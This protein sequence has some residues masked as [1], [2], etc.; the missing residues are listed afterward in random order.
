MTFGHGALVALYRALLDQHGPQAWWP[1]E[2]PFEIM[3]GALLIQRTAWRNAEQALARL[4]EAALLDPARLRAARAAELEHCVRPAGFFR[5][6]SSRLR[7]LAAW[8]DD[9]GGIDG[10]A[11]RDTLALRGAL[12]ALDGIGPE[13]ADAIL[14][15]ALERPVFVV[16]AYLRRVWSRLGLIAGT[17][18]YEALRAAIESAL[19][20]DTVVYNEYHALLVAH[21]QRYC[22]PAPRCA[23]CALGPGCGFRA[24]AARD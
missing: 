4:R 9:A 7:Q 20:P 6:K 12:L 5:Q 15:Y 23:E 2:S 13:T 21:G 18:S 3:A 11:V 14:L 16:D 1:G 8:V 24:A 10:L 17:E 19:P 22:R